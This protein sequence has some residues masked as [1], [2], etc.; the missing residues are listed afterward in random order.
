L[1][2]GGTEKQEK[3]IQS[4]EKVKVYQYDISIIF[5]TY[6]S[7]FERSKNSLVS[8]LTQKDIRFEI[9]VA[10]DGSKD[11]HERELRNLFSEYHFIDYKLVMNPKNQ[12]TVK[13]LLSG[14]TLAEGKY[15][16]A[17][18]PGDKFVAEDTLRY[19]I[20]FMDRRK[21]GWS[22]SDA[23]YYMGQKDE[24]VYVSVEAHPQDLKPYISNNFLRCRWNYIVLNDIALGA[25]ILC[26]TDLIREYS[27]LLADYGVIY[28]EDNMWRLLMFMG[29]VGCY[30]PNAA[31]Y[32]EY[33]TGI[34]TSGDSLWAQRLHVDWNN[35]D[36]IMIDMENLDKFQKKVLRGME[37]SNSFL[38][39]IFIKGKLIFRIKLIFNK[40][41]TECNR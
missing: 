37:K 24:E 38:R 7:S 6:N 29:D 8:I 19:W 25:S 22:F 1:G 17:I 39:K 21:C 18:S 10:D 41:M 35:T 31:I 2:G 26:R 27:E 23:V 9:I 32:Y 34:S 12:G 40:R 3:S 15:T 16:K 36:K 20:D 28:A 11:N 5:V 13:N 4:L 33:G 14:I 30:Y